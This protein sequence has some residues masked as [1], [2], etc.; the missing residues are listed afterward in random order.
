MAEK[1][2]KATKTAKPVQGTDEVEQVTTAIRRRTPIT[3][4]IDQ[5]RG[6][7]HDRHRGV[8][9]KSV[10]QLGHPMTNKH[11]QR[12]YEKMSQYLFFIPVIGRALLTAKNEKDVTAAERTVR[13]TITKAIQHIES[14]TAQANAVA[15][16]K[17]VSTGSWNK[18]F[19]IEVSFASPLDKLF[20]ELI[21]KADE[22]LLL[23]GALWI[24]G[25]LAD[26]YDANERVRSDN[27]LAVKRT[28]R[29][30][31]YG[32]MTNHQRIVNSIRRDQQS[33]PKVASKATTAETENVGHEV[34]ALVDAQ[35]ESEAATAA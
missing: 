19:A 22:F 23:N 21:S 26:E 12:Y 7:W 11:Y 16:S 25:A 33:G 6:R 10:H 28:I 9:V 35:R 34:T 5:Q 3:E 29:N 18:P 32:I 13:T 17:Q 4:I 1:A 30:V 24:E 15:S 20:F 2:A 8:V 31:L 27:E 14:L